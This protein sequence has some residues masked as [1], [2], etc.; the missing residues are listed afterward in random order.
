MNEGS[1]FDARTL[2]EEDRERWIWKRLMAYAYRRNPD[3]TTTRDVVQ[4]TLALVLQGDGW[5]AWRFDPEAGHDPKR[6]LL[7]HLCSVARATGK[8]QRKAMKARREVPMPA[9]PDPED[10]NPK[11]LADPAFHVEDGNLEHAEHLRWEGLAEQVRGRLDARA[12]AVL[13]L[14][15][16]DV[17]DAAAQAERLACSVAEVYLARDRIAYHRD[18]V[19]ALDAKTREEEQQKLVPS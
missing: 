16:E 8:D 9:A 5:L 1:T 14:E 13:A 17:H 10:D 3:L 18:A 4:E 2:L 11:E 12:R 6:S 15:E 19:L 7:L